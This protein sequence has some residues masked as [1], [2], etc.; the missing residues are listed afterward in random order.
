VPRAGA[1]RLAVY[2]LRGR[3]VRVLADAPL[4]AG[5]HES[6]WDGTD[7]AGRAVAAGVYVL[8]LQQGGAAATAK[9]VLAK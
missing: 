9:L 1:A 8:R 7:G 6:S 2:D 5:R 4:P 3:L